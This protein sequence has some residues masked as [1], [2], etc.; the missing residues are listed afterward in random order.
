MM[1]WLFVFTANFLVLAAT[2]QVGEMAT[3]EKDRFNLY[4]TYDQLSV[5]SNNFDINYYRCEWTIDPAIRFIAGTVTSYFTITNTT[6]NIVFD[7]N[8]TLTVDSVLYHGNKIGFLQNNNNSLQVNLPLTLNG[9]QK[10]S[11]S[12]FYK[13][14]P[15]GGAFA[16]SSHAGTPILWT[17]SEPYG[18]PTWWPCRD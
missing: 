17:L 14:I 3:A 1:K 10:D 11:V 9:N 18:A 7:L 16:T 13:G 6:N 4:R 5:S 12:I 2:A 15:P 8:K